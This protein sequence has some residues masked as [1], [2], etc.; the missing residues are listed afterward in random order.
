[1]LALAHAGHSEA[2]R[3][4]DAALAHASRELACRAMEHADAGTFFAGL[5]VALAE[6]YH[7]P[8]SVRD[9]VDDALDGTGNPNKRDITRGRTST[10]S[11]VDAGAI[12]H[13]GHV[14]PDDVRH[15]R[16]LSPRAATAAQRPLSSI[17]RSIAKHLA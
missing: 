17:E 16:S 11:P 13:D 14:L 15:A 7:D 4:S 6:T 8:D 10:V 1:M 3:T 2:A 12:P 5:Q 9:D